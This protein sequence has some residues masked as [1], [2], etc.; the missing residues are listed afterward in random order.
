[1]IKTG[2]VPLNFTLIVKQSVFCAA[3]LVD[4]NNHDLPIFRVGNESTQVF[5][6]QNQTV[7]H[8]LKSLFQKLSV[9]VTDSVTGKRIHALGKLVQVDPDLVE[10]II[11]AFKF[12]AG[13]VIKYYH[14]PFGFVKYFEPQKITCAPIL[15]PFDQGIQPDLFF[16]GHQK[17]N[18]DRPFLFIK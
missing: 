8:H 13:L 7:S 16:F 14:F 3:G 11:Q 4:F 18:N 15:S 9:T 5:L 2:F 10:L 1:V 6:K 12:I 17:T